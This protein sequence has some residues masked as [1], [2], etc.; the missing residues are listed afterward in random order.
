MH[1]AQL[2]ISCIGMLKHVAGYLD[3]GSFCRRY[4]DGVPVDVVESA[5]GDDGLA[6]QAG[7]VDG[8]LV[9]GLALP[10][11]IFA[12][13]RIHHYIVVDVHEL[14]VFHRTAGGVYMYADVAADG[15]AGTVQRHARLETVVDAAFIVCGGY[16]VVDVLE[17]RDGLAVSCSIQGLG[18]RGVLRVAYFRLVSLSRCAHCH[19]CSRHENSQQQGKHCPLHVFF[20]SLFTM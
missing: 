15:V 9:A 13:I 17:Q 16:A 1:I 2:S 6:G 20:S 19:Q 12:G 5:A 18:Q 4:L 11:V 3:P 8:A 7:G 10:A 14:D